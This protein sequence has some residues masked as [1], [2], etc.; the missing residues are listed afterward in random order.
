M[1]KHKIARAVRKEVR[2]QLRREMTRLRLD[3]I[4]LVRFEVAASRVEYEGIQ[5]AVDGVKVPSDRPIP[6]WRTDVDMS[7]EQIERRLRGRDG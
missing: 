7:D 1:S 4:G 3:T 5:E 6:F 2:Y